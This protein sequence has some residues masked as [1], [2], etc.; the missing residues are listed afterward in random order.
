MLISYAL[1][2]GKKKIAWAAV[3]EYSAHG[4]GPWLCAIWVHPDHRRRGWARKLMAEI[5]A[6]YPGKTI[7]L[8]PRQG[9]GEELGKGQLIFIFKKLGF[10]EY[11]ADGRMKKEIS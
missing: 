10:K 7:R 11:D 6:D 1:R 5:E 8:K 3:K 9:R 2:S 4:D